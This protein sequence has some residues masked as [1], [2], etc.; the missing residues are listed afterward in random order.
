MGLL[1]V[2]KYVIFFLIIVGDVYMCDFYLVLF[3]VGGD[4]GDFVCFFGLRS[5]I[6]LLYGF[7]YFLGRIL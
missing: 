6:W 3:F 2:L 5:V 4:D 7:I 1:V